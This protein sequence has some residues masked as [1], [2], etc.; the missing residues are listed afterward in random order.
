VSGAALL[1]TFMANAWPAVEDESHDG[2][3][4]RWADGATRRANSALA[5]GTNG[6]IADLVA[7]AE[8]FYRRRSAPTSIQVSTASAPPELPAYLLS[9]GYRSTARTLVQIAQTSEVL[10]RARPT[11]DAE[12]TGALTPQW[13]DAYWSVE[14]SRHHNEATK[15]VYRDVLLVPRLPTI[16]ACAH[17]PDGIAGVGQLVVERNWAGVQCMATSPDH[18]RGGIARNI[19]GHLAQQASKLHIGQMY[20][21][22]MANNDPATALYANIGFRTMHEYSYF[23]DSQA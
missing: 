11:F 8:A 14:S 4:Y 18:R 1:D 12:I 19:I 2:W 3:R 5:L 20:L 7:R 10:E 16:F 17:R 13:L 6:N 21:A 23:T 15:A 22:V 9:S